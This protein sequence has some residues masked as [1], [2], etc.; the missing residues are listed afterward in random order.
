MSFRIGDLVVCNEYSIAFSRLSFYLVGPED[1]VAFVISKQQQ[2]IELETP[3]ESSEIASPQDK[4]VLCVF[5]QY[6]CYVNVAT[7]KALAY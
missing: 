2:I 4:F 1:G 5:K 7:L 3:I 6:I